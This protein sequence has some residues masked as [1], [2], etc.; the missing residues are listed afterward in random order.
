MILPVTRRVE[1]GAQPT[2]RLLCWTSELQSHSFT[3]SGIASPMSLNASACNVSAE[4]IP[5]LVVYRP[6]S[7]KRAV[8]PVRSKP[9]FQRSLLPQW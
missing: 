5:L 9:S 2:I 3:S 1:L 7:E 6:S 4:T 8:H